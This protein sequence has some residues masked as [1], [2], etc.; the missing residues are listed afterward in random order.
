MVFRKKNAELDTICGP[1]DET[2]ESIRSV[3]PRKAITS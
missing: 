2:L 1:G 3:S